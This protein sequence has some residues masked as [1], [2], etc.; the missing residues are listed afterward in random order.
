MT[1]L[2]ASGAP[3]TDRTGT[4]PFMALQLL[5][6]KNV[7]HMFRH[8]A[9]S[10]IWLFLWVCGCSNGPEKQALVEPYRTWR[11]LNML[12]CKEEREAFLSTADLHDINVSMHHAPCTKQLVLPISGQVVAAT[13]H[14]CLEDGLNK[15][16]S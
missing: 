8:D 15:C 6:S 5:S 13:L 11:S 12:A 7:A 1:A 14:I 16:A 10:F 2:S 4:I 9:E 3:N